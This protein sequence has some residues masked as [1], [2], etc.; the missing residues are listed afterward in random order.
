MSPYQA[1]INS[2]FLAFLLYNCGVHGDLSVYVF[3]NLLL[4]LLIRFLPR[5]FRD[6]TASDFS[7]SGV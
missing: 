3:V 7:F 2:H 5:V 1:T 4:D 6:F